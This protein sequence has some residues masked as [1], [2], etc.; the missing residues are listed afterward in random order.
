MAAIRGGTARDEL[1]RQQ[2][3]D[4]HGHRRDAE[5]HDGHDGAGDDP[6]SAEANA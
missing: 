4:D 3:K 5:D 2:A 6:L 1:Q